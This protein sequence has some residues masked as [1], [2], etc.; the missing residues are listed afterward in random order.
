M[1]S[2]RRFRFTPPPL[3]VQLPIQIALSIAMNVLSFLYYRRYP[4]APWIVPL[5][6]L[7][8]LLSLTLLVGALRFFPP[9]RTAP[10]P[11]PVDPEHTASS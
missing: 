1:R 11:T 9:D 8:T 3:R 7:I 4:T 5:D 10:T 2:S 6:L